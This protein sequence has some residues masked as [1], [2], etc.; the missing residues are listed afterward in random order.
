VTRTVARLQIVLLDDNER[1][2]GRFDHDTDHRYTLNELVEHPENGDLWL[3]CAIEQAEPPFAQRVTW[4]Y[5]GHPEA[6]ANLAKPS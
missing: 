4:I 2:S 5:V 3:V 6:G 1:E